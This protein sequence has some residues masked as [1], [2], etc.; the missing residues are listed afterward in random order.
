MLNIQEQ[1]EVKQI[2]KDLLRIESVQ[3]QGD[4][5]LVVQYIQELFQKEDIKI[6]RV[7]KEEN[8][9]NL[10]ATIK[11]GAKPPILLLSHVDVVPPQG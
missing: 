6:Q 8:R 9:Q 10:I 2:L 4:E 5:T 7:A 11:G 3:P 1:N